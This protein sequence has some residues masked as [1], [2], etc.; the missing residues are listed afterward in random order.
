LIARCDIK[1][2]SALGTWRVPAIIAKSEKLGNDFYPRGIRMLHL[3]TGGLHLDE[4]NAAQVSKQELIKPWEPSGSFLHRGSFKRL[5]AISG[6]PLNVNLDPI[7]Y[8]NKI[9]NLLEQH[10]VWSAI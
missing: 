2:R 6:K 3:P 7:E 5:L 10:V 4:R 8:S 1:D 9:L